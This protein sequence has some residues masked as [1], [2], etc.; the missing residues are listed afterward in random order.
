MTQPASVERTIPADST[1][2]GPASSFA[3]RIEQ[4]RDGNKVA[5]GQLLDENRSWLRRKAARLLGDR[6]AAQ[7]DPSD[8][9]QDCLAA[10]AENLPAF[11]GSRG[12]AFRAWLATILTNKFRALV[13]P[14]GTLAKAVQSLPQDS[15]GQLVLADDGSS[16]FT[17]LA[18]N[19][20]AALL[21]AGL[22]ELDEAD[23]TL[24]VAHFVQGSDYAALAVERQTTAA[25]LRQQAHRT[26]ARLRAGLPL[27]AA[28]ERS[29]MPPH[30]RGVL[31]AARLRNWSIA[32]IATAW[33][34]TPRAARALVQSSEDWL[35]RTGGR[36]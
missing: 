8:L 25:N 20:A 29:Q 18:R 2:E 6:R 16:V 24:I 28:I 5:A 34:L 36:R 27:L 11:R 15:M 19:D 21:R 4:A 12:A 7:V 10:A 23:R 33:N 3:G 1:S 17:R 31:C 13:R 22:A 35:Q 14:G 30:Y 26:L 9:A 32:Q